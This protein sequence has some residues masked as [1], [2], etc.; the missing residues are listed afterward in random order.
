[1]H[2]HLVTERAPG[3]FTFHDLLRD[4][5]A[6]HARASDTKDER[7][8][9]VGRLLDWYLYTTDAA[10]RLLYPHTVRLPPR[11]V[12]PPTAPLNLDDRTEALA[13]LD[14]ERPNLLAIIRHAARNGPRS[15][16][17]LLADALRAYFMAR[18]HT[19]DWLA[20]ADVGLAAARADGDLRAEAAALLSLGDAHQRLS[21]YAPAVNR[22][23]QALDLARR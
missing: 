12:E 17:W 4:Y 22:Y 19:T 2:A 10:V 9:A 11:A 1:T 7:E 20:I 16:A 21:R 13:W 14:A 23:T 8:A 18:M 5:A 15:A 6:E 3:R